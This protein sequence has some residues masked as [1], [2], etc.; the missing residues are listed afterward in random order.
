MTDIPVSSAPV[1]S[2]PASVAEFDVAPRGANR[3]LAI[4]N[5]KGGVGKTTTAINL[6]TALAATGRRVMLFD[7]DPQGN[8]S[9]GLGID[10]NAAESGSYEVLIGGAP[11]AAAAV[12]TAVPELVVVPASVDLYGA[13]LELVDTNGRILADAVRE[14]GGE[15]VFLGVFRD[16]L[17]ALRAGVHRALEDSDLVL[18][19]GGTSKGD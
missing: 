8:A 6:S 9:T 16:D 13:E 11:I 5:Q 2:T 18:L 3:I 12:Q 17:D 14:L 1:S 15:P 10:R 7:L 4:A 19:S